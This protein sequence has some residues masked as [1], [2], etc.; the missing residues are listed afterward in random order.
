VP[1]QVLAETYRLTPLAALP[2]PYFFTG[3]GSEN[4]DVILY[5]VRE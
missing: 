4:R 2:L 3:G 5:E 1:R